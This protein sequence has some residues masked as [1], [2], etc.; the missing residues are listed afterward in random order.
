MNIN[1]KCNYSF[2]KNIIE[3][4]GLCCQGMIYQKI[5]KIRKNTL[6]KDDNNCENV[7][8]ITN[9]TMEDTH[10][11]MSCFWIG[12]YIWAIPLKVSIKLLM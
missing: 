7:G 1:I 10:N 12:N 8:Y 9:L 2:R 5:L 4:S 11:I 3:A 6:N